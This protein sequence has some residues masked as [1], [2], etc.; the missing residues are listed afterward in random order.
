MIG[1]IDYGSGNFTSV[2]NAVILITNDIKVIRH[3]KDFDECSHI[4]LPGVGVYGQAIKKLKDLNLINKMISEVIIN[5]KPFLGI[6]VG[7]QI[8]SE[9]GFEFQEEKGLGLVEG[10]VDS[11]SF[12]IEETMRLPHIG[13]NAVHNYE[14]NPL[15]KDIEPEESD[16]Y[17]VHSFHLRST[18]KDA[19]FVYTDYGYNFISAFQKGNIFGVQFHPEKSQQNGIRLLTNFIN[20]A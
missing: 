14:S 13:W 11:F 1:I 12:E 16:F 9:K 2:Y 18:D 3:E 5:K 10:E 15:F 4:I 6:C 7:M 17:F 20:Y 8:L 19:E